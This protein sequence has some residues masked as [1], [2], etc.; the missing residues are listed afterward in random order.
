MADSWL[1]LG[2]IPALSSVWPM[3]ASW[4]W[5]LRVRLPS[6]VFPVS[7]AQESSVSVWNFFMLSSYSACHCWRLASNCAADRLYSAAHCSSC[8]SWE[9]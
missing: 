1:S 5:P 2:M 9:R 3:L 4:L 7:C 6:L 8:M